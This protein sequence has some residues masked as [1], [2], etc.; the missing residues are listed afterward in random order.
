MPSSTNSAVSFLRK[1][2][3]PAAVT[4]LLLLIVIFFRPA[5]GQD[6]FRHPEHPLLDKDGRNVLDSGEPVSTM[7]T[8]GACHD[9]EF[10]T[11]HSFHV[12]V[13]LDEFTNAG[14]TDS[15]R[16]WDS[17]PGYFGR[18][19]PI[20]YRYLSPQGDEVVD[21]TTAEWLETLGIRQVGGGPAEFSRSG[22]RLEGIPV[23]AGNVETSIIDLESGELIPWDW[24]ESGTIE[25][26]CF[27]CHTPQ[28][29]NDA[30][31]ETMRAGEF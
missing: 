31:M 22:E 14:E 30:R 1:L 24:S 21:L 3:I 8:C 9:T 7:E 18:W 10:I 16:S 19:N 15:A 6:S 29:N 5:F 17:S 13:G 23:D 25:M 2:R 20:T 11:S 28:P 12:D 27:L 4:L 26:N